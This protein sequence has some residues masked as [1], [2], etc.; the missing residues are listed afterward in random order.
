MILFLDELLKTIFHWHHTQPGLRAGVVVH[1]RHGCILSIEFDLY[2]L[3]PCQNRCLFPGFRIFL[4]LLVL[5]GFS[6]VALC[7]VTR[8]KFLICV[9]IYLYNSLLKIIQLL[10][11][12]TVGMMP[13]FNIMIASWIISS[14]MS[15]EGLPMHRIFL[16]NC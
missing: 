14:C 4:Q 6:M 2:H 7:F 9:M 16:M 10:F 12:S 15:G 11:W 3:I 5:F 1:L 13:F 8:P